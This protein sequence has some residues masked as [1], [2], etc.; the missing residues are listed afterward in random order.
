MKSLLKIYGRYI[1]TAAVIIILILGVNMAILAGITV[2]YGLGDGK[3]GSNI[4]FRQVAEGFFVDSGTDEPVVSEMGRAYLEG[5]N[6]VFAMLLS[7]TGAV[8]WDWNIPAELPRQYTVGE[9]ASFSRWYLRDY[10]VRVWNSSEGL[11]VIGYPKGSTWKHSVE[12]TEGY[13]EN[14]AFYIKWASLLNLLLIAGVIVLLGYRFY[15]S[16]RPL[17]A[18]IKRLSEGRTVELQEKGVVME[19][20]R[21]LNR[22]S[23]ILEK[24]HQALEKRD[25]ARTNWISGVSHDIR[26]PL[27]MVMGYADRLENEEELKPELKKQAG[28]IKSQALRIRRLIE[29]LNLTSKLEYDMQP[30]RISRVIPTAFLRSLAAGYLNEGLDEKYEL[31]LDLDEKLEHAVL[32]GDEALLI[33]SVRNLIDNSIRHNPD[34][35]RITVSGQ[36]LPGKC[37]LQVTDDGAG[38]P[39]QVA[40]FVNS[41]CGHE[42][43]EFH[44]MGLRITAQI[45]RAHQGSLEIGRDLHSVVLTM[46]LSES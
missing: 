7:D 8:I 34:G 5:K 1:A 35:C 16:L 6:A 23:R 14:I 19:L 32:E 28:I 27:S 9:V 22:T 26:T 24:Q 13:V 41:G 37:R 46:P 45:M 39:P 33:R 42:E 36:M 4:L 21:S 17:T 43:K 40:D 18:G 20:C 10:P 3:K 25:L 38:I 15:R 31:S 44:I 12:F 29:D 11:L 2:R 30:L